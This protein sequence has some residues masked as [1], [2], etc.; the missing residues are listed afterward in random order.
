MVN[1]GPAAATSDC[2]C[3]TDEMTLLDAPKLA[4][5]LRHP[6]GEAAL[7]VAESMNR[8]N[9]ALN[10]AAIALL[11][12]APG[13]HVLEI[14]PGNAAFAG[15]LLRAPGSRYLGIE[16]SQAM[17]QAGNA[18]LA[19]DG[20]R[21]RASVQ[22]GDVHALDLPDASVDAALAVNLL[23]FWPQLS[24]PLCE[25]ARVLRPGGRLCLAFGDAA[26]MRTLPFTAHG[27][28]L[29]SLG[30]VEPALRNNGFSVC[31]WR[32]HRE[33]GTSNDGRT[34]DKHFHL[35]LARRSAG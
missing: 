19:A 16:V 2:P 15:Q 23:Y 8:S 26:F 18:R 31:G 13:E 4:A 5:Q 24:P 20:L 28:H 30:E 3:N 7:A 35:L 25:L 10:Q 9:G 29:Y 32:A 22:H 14:G 34:L 21:D 1:S 6:H 27:F 11:A 33:H 12:T 17:V